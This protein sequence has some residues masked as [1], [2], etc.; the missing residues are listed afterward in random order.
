M[1]FSVA[2]CK[3]MHIRKNNSSYLCNLDLQL[4]IAG[5]PENTTLMLGSGQKHQSTQRT[6]MSVK[7]GKQKHLSETMRN[8]IRYGNTINAI[9]R[10]GLCPCLQY[11]VSTGM[12]RFGYVDRNR[13]SLFKCC[14]GTMEFCGTWLKY[15]I[16]KDRK[17]E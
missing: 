17:E 11:N 7:L 1:K 5:L 13:I 2:T 8:V 16:R 9:S 6:G 14:T 10:S 12:T 4:I 15:D 3:V